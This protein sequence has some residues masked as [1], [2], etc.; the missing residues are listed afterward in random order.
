[1]AFSIPALNLLVTWVGYCGERIYFEQLAQGFVNAIV[2][3]VT[4]LKIFG[5]LAFVIL[6]IWVKEAVSFTS[7]KTVWSPSCFQ[8]GWCHLRSLISEVTDVSTA[9]IDNVPLTIE[10]E[11]NQTLALTLEL[12]RDF[13]RSCY[14]RRGFLGDSEQL[15]VR[16]DK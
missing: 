6:A 9:F 8:G 4:P 15:N 13:V 3:E 11:M 1:M 14:K 10:H 5:L 16:E 12:R 2:F 7:K